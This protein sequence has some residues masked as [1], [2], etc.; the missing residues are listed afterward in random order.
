MG[1]IKNQATRS[2]YDFKSGY[3][4]TAIKAARELQYKPEVIDQINNAKND[5]EIST[6]MYLA[7]KAIGE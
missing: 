4:R 5:S 3:K 2:N 1:Q 6:I 7:A